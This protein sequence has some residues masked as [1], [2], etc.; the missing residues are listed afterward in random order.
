[1]TVEMDVD[2]RLVVEPESHAEAY[3]LRKWVEVNSHEASEYGWL[4]NLAYSPEVAR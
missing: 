2:G 4:V 3:A 1:M